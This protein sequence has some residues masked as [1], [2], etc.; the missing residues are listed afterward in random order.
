MVLMAQKAASYRYPLVD[1]QKLGR[2]MIRS[3]SAA[4]CYTES[5]LVQICLLL[6]QANSRSDGGLR[7]TSTAHG[8]PVKML[9]ALSLP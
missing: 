3:H 4:M 9:P 5:R 7:Q 2:R 6:R 8:K 1:G